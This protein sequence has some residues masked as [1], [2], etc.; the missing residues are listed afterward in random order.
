MRGHAPEY[1]G[2]T[3]GQGLIIVKKDYKMRKFS[4]KFFST[5]AA[6][7]TVFMVFGNLLSPVRAQAAGENPPGVHVA[8]MGIWAERL[9]SIPSPINALPLSCDSEYRPMP[10]SL[11][12]VVKAS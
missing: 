8:L 2:H 4:P 5:V 9:T 1:A 12:R 7:V 6:A 10:R 11:S 3:G